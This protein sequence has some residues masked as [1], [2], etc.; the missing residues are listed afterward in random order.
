MQLDNNETPK[1]QPNQFGYN[2]RLYKKQRDQTYDL[3]FN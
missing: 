1:I 2:Y 3:D